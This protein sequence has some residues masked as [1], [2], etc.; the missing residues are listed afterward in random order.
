VGP[1]KHLLHSGPLNSRQ[2]LYSVHST[3]YSHLVDEL[4]VLLSNEIIRDWSLVFLG[5]DVD[6][7]DCAHRTR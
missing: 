7:G 1:R 4:K 5:R 2:I 6:V 3:Q